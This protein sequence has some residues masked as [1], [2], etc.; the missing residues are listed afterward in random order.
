MSQHA[1]S[2]RQAGSSSKITAESGRKTVKGIRLWPKEKFNSAI[3]N[4]TDLDID[5][6]QMISSGEWRTMGLAYCLGMPLV[7]RVSKLTDSKKIN[8]AAAILSI[9]VNFK[10]SDHDIA[11]KGFG[12]TSNDDVYGAID[13]KRID[14]K[15]LHYEDVEALMDYV[16]D[17]FPFMEL[18]RSKNQYEVR[19]E[20]TRKKWEAYGNPKKFEEYWQTW[21]DEKV[22][23]GAEEQVII[24]KHGVEVVQVGSD[25][26]AYKALQCPV[27][28]ELCLR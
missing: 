27:V 26:E 24:T 22:R 8:D 25:N 10:Q 11:I 5:A 16:K 9:N 3:Q 4:S 14:R 12:T 15:D 2:Q 17:R 7:C 21:K 6:D 23:R 13:I 20:H 18:L 1:Q 28:R 19:V